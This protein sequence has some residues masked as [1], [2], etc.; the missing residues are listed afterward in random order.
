MARAFLCL[1]KTIP[2]MKKKNI[3]LP[4]PSRPESSV[5]LR[6]YAGLTTDQVSAAVVCAT[7]KLQLSRKEILMSLPVSIEVC[8]C[9]QQSSGYIT[10]IT[11]EI[12]KA[13]GMEFHVEQRRLSTYVWRLA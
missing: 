9:F 12:E 7:P 8:A 11:D 10:R 1:D 6:G 5:L 2:I 4:T 3:A 13:T